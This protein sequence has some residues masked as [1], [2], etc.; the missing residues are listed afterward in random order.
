[1]LIEALANL[2]E[3]TGA[4]RISLEIPPSKEGSCAVMV[5]TSFGHSVS[6]N[7]SKEHGALLAA[8]AA[9]LVVEGHVGELDARLVAML[10]ELE[11]DF[12][13]ASRSLPETDT[14]RRKRELKEAAEKKEAKTDKKA[15]TKK[16]KTA[17]SA[18]TP[19]DESGC[20]HT[21]ALASGEADSL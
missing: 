13:E 11:D 15:T 7:E 5:V 21:D 20:S 9:P 10:D 14:Q 19:A 16:A 18:D 6:V 3:K 17:E 8:L 12:A 4:E 2:A 1:M